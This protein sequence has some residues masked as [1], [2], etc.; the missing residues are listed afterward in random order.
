[1]KLWYTLLLTVIV[2]RTRTHVL[3]LTIVCAWVSFIGNPSRQFPKPIQNTLAPSPFT[4]PFTSKLNN[5]LT[6]GLVLWDTVPIILFL[7]KILTY[8]SSITPNSFRCLLFSNYASII[9]QGL[10]T[11]LTNSAFQLAIVATETPI[12]RAHCACISAH[13]HWCAGKG[14]R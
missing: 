6:L 3:L 9:C 2:V 5:C 14:C 4:R 11:S 7:P 12:D 8:Y 1:M 10:P 13:A